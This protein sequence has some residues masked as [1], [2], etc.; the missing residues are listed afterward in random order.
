[1]VVVTAE[2]GSGMWRWWRAVELGVHLAVLQR[3]EPARQLVVEAVELL[4]R[5]RVK[6][7]AGVRAKV[8]GLGL[9]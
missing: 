6:V 4:C 5:V 1:M 9:S 8:I 3:L 2:G 7:R